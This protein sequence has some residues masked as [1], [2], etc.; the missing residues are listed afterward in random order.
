[1]AFELPG[2]YGTFLCS[3]GI[4][5]YTFVD[6]TSTGS[7]A[8]KVAKLI[9]P[10]TYGAVVGVLVSSGTTGSTVRKSQTVQFLGISKVRAGSTAFVAGD[11]VLATTKGIANRV[12]KGT[13]STSYLCGVCV[14]PLG[15]TKEGSTGDL[16]G[17]EVISILLTQPGTLA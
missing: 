8:S 12:A 11:Y 17:A 16:A 7:G 2:F 4:K 15:S 13:A 3:T 6:L 14:A 1:M 5:Q 9:K 10:T